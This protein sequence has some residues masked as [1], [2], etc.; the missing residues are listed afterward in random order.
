MFKIKTKQEIKK[1][2]QI[3]DLTIVGCQWD[4]QAL[5]SLDKVAQSLLNLTELF[6]AQHI[7]VSLGTDLNI[8]RGMSVG[9]GKTIT[10][11]SKEV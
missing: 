4:A 8:E 11:D 2:I 5:E 7:T 10:K 6:K 1:P 9:I 3:R